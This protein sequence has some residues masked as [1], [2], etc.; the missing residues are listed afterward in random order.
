MA[1]QNVSLGKYWKLFPATCHKTNGDG[2]RKEC[3]LIRYS[4]VLEIFMRIKAFTAWTF[5][6][7]VILVTVIVPVGA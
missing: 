4:R 6:L 2:N 7:G 3:G 1:H 5:S